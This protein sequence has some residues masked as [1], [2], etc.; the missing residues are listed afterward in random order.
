[1]QEALGVEDGLGR[2]F[3]NLRDG[4]ARDLCGL[5][6]IRMTTHAVDANHQGRA[7]ARGDLH[8]I[9]ILAA[10]PEEGQF[11]VFDLQG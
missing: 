3:K 8:P 1:M 7:I 10:I 2:A 6:A 5:G 11:C 9:L 4:L